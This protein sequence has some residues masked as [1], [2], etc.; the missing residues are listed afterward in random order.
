M[1]H[2]LQLIMILMYH[3]LQ[4]IMILMYHTLQLIM[5]PPLTGNLGDTCRIHDDCSVVIDFSTCSNGACACDLGYVATDD[6]TGCRLLGFNDLCIWTAAC[7]AAIKNTRCL[8]GRCRCARGWF[9]DK[10]IEAC[11]KRQLGDACADNG[12]CSAAVEK[13][14]CTDRK[15]SCE[16]NH[17]RF[18]GDESRCVVEDVAML[19]SPEDASPVVSRD[20]YVVTF[21][22]IAICILALVDIC[23]VL[24]LCAHFVW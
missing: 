20:I 21:S 8:D 3:T 24:L 5:S 15:C 11:V 4:L 13:S 9:W 18:E 6:R 16:P 1:Y 17:S 7:K 12:D 23:L 2:T 22:I 19:V 10:N 14:V